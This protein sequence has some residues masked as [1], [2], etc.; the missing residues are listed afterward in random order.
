MH[1]K[2]TEFISKYTK[3]FQTQEIK[4][5]KITKNVEVKITIRK[6]VPDTDEYL[7]EEEV[8]KEEVQ[9]EGEEGK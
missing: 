8:Q 2:L 7:E 5:S 9:K 4:L 3:Y 6:Y 1:S